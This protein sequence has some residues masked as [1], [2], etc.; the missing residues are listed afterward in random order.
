LER[1]LLARNLKGLNVFDRHTTHQS[2]SESSTLLPNVFHGRI[3]RIN[4]GKIDHV[5]DRFSYDVVCL[6]GPKGSKSLRFRVAIRGVLFI[7]DVDADG[8]AEEVGKRPVRKIEDITSAHSK[9]LFEEI[10]FGERQIGH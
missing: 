3:S 9:K 7:V 1:P 8:L 6:D 2:L 5:G 10:F 4:F